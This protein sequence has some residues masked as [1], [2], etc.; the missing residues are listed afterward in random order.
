MMR[1]TK[2]LSKQHPLLYTFCTNLRDAIFMLNQNDIEMVRSKLKES[3]AQVDL[4]TKLKF[5]PEWVY[6]RVRRKINSP[7]DMKKNLNQ[8]REKFSSPAFTVKIKSKDVPLLNSDT[9]TALN[10]LIQKHLDCLAAIP[11]YHCVKGTNAVE[12][13]H[14]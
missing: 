9:T 12:S 4:D 13:Y 1:V 5:D 7:S 10:D 6:K 11:V 8:L 14:Q 3:Q 2:T